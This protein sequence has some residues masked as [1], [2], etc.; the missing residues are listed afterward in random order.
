MSKTG[1]I[2]ECLIELQSLPFEQMMTRDKA[3][4]M[5]EIISN[6]WEELHRLNES[7]S[8]LRYLMDDCKGKYPGDTWIV[9]M[10]IEGWTQQ[11][12]GR[13]TPPTK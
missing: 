8:V 7:E 11:E 10:Q 13:W 2:A 9:D 5:L 12:D 4:Q 6:A 3:A 1:W